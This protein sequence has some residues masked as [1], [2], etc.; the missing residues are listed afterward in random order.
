MSLSPHLWVETLLF[1]T[2]WGF[3]SFCNSNLLLPQPASTRLILHRLLRDSLL[4]PMLRLTQVFPPKLSILLFKSLFSLASWPHV[5]FWMCANSL[6]L[7][8]KRDGYQ[9]ARHESSENQHRTLYWLKTSQ[10]S[11]H[12]PPLGITGTNNWVEAFSPPTK[13]EAAL[14]LI[15][16]DI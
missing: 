11:L 12:T 10:P 13:L 7:Q 1:S 8:N 14:H 6:L 4:G 16:V 9:R 5:R 2:V 15:S 3:S